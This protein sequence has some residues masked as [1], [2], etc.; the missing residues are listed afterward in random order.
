MTTGGTTHDKGA[1]IDHR[2]FVIKCPDYDH[3]EERLTELLTAMGGMSRFASPGETIVLKPNLLQAA[4]P[5]KAITTHPALVA[6]MAKMVKEAG[7]TA[8][9]A[10]SPGSGYRYNEKTLDRV[11]RTCGMDAAAEKTG[12]V[13]NYDT[14]YQAVSFPGGR[15]VKRFEVITPVLEAD[16]VFNLCKLKTHALT[17]ITGAVKNLFGVIPGLTKPGYHA[18][19]REKDY[20]SGALLDLAA[21]ISPRLSIIDAVVAMEGDGPGAGDPSQVGLLLAATNP[22]SLDVVASEIIG[23]PRENNPLLI[24]AEKRDLH[25]NHLDEVELVGADSVELRIPDFALPSTFLPGTGISVWWH[26][27]LASMFGGTLSVTPRTR[28][29]RCVACD[30]CRNACPVHAI[31]IIEEKHVHIDKRKCIRCYCCHE[32][33]ANDAI[34]LHTSWLNHLVNR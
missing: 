25:P 26:K 33:C 10:D 31:T 24:E 23:L 14:T 5:E 1:L 3:V 19:L 2:A 4:P 27:A 28:K 22:L 9:V 16:A 18:K 34:G 15:L 30:V 29:D 21:C 32:M 13:L 8:V 11:Y 12:A 17:G 7:A 20:F 6:A